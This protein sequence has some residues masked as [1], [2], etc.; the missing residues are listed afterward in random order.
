LSPASVKQRKKNV[1]A[2][3]SKDKA[4]LAKY[5]KFDATLDDSQH[6]EDY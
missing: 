1:Q 4:L 5:A 2:E 3:R 6:N